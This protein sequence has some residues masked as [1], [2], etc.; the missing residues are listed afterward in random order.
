MFSCFMLSAA[1]RWGT[2]K[3][4]VMIFAV[5]YWGWG[6]VQWKRCDYVYASL[7]GREVGSNRRGSA[8]TGHGGL[9]IYRR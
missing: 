2:C 3:R 1:F 5:V 4:L 9:D 8:Q 7:L 6:W